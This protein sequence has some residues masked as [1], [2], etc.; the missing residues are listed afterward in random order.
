MLQNLRKQMYVGKGFVYYSVTPIKRVSQSG[1][2]DTSNWLY[3]VPPNFY[4]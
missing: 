1:L 2:W 4:H 3:Q